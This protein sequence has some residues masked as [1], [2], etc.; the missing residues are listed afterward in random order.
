VSNRPNR[1]QQR[2]ARGLAKRESISYQAALAQIE[3]TA[4]PQVDATARA[5]IEARARKRHTEEEGA[6]VGP[7]RRMLEIMYETF[8]P[9]GKWPL[10]QYV[11]AHWEE[12]QVEPR[13]TYLDLAKRGLVRPEIPRS[14]ELQLREETVVG[15]SLRGLMHLG[16][17]AEDLDRFVV[18]VRYVARCARESRS[19]SAIGL[20]P[21]ELGPLLIT[22]ED[23]RVHLELEPGDPAVARLGTLVR[24][25]AW[26]LWTSFGKIDSG[27]WSFEVDLERAQRYHD[28]N[29]ILRYFL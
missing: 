5:Q 16:R 19:L 8:A 20:G 1:K 11:S 10:F 18:I 22:S 13:E 25:E 15:V 6:V 17:A 7:H 12:M 28:L 26:Q 2:L 21:I 14:R 4:R 27:G 24:D 9:T 3:G 23:I 29:V